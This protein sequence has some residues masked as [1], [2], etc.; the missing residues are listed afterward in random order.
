[1]TSTERTSRQPPSSLAAL[2]REV[3]DDLLALDRDVLARADRGHRDTF[4]AQ[5]VGDD[6]GER[7]GV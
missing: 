2:R 4:L 3:E 6:L 5:R 7:L 1:L